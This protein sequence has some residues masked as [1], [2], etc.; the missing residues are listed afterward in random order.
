MDLAKIIEL[1][2]EFY[3]LGLP[4]V[5]ARNT[6]RLEGRVDSRP[7]VGVPKPDFAELHDG[8]PFKLGNLDISKWSTN[9]F[10]SK[11][12]HTLLMERGITNVVIAGTPRCVRA[13]V[14][15]NAQL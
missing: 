2:N 10:L 14:L 5:W 8:P 13:L 7:P 6:G 3:E 1:T 12:L 4:I 9:A 11:E 15:V